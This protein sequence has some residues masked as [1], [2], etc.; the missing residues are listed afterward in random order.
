VLPKT[1][2]V[3]PDE[4]FLRGLMYA[5]IPV[6]NLKLI[7]DRRVWE[8]EKQNCWHSSSRTDHLK[9][10]HDTK[11]VTTSQRAGKSHLR[12]R[13]YLETYTS[14]AWLLNLSPTSA[15]FPS[16]HSQWEDQKVIRPFCRLWRR[17]VTTAVPQKRQSKARIPSLCTYLCT[18]Y[19]CIEGV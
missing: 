19:I 11:L 6:G 2:K 12:Q 18:K 8:A 9:Q 10:W 7:M 16:R 17:T 14:C 15:F 3:D 4:T 13:N 1:H 5:R